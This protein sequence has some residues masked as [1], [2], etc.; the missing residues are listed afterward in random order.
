[1][2]L[3]RCIYSCN[4]NITAT[5][6]DAN[7]RVSFKNCAPFTKYI[8]HLNDEHYNPDNLDIIMPMYNLIEYSNNYS[9]TSGSLW[10]FKRDKQ[11]M[12]NGNPA[13]VTTADSSSANINQVFLNH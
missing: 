6:Y 4:R 5:D 12:N 13:N 2:W 9:D 3:F 8:I 7:I 1:M 10:Q 11:N